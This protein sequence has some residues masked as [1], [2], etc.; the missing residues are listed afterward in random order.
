MMTTNSAAEDFSVDAIWLSPIQKDTVTS[1]YV[2]RVNYQDRNNLIVETPP[3]VL[4]DIELLVDGKDKSGVHK[5]LV[6]TRLQQSNPE[7]RRLIHTIDRQLLHNSAFRNGRRFVPCLSLEESF[8]FYIPVY[9]K[10]ISVLVT[11][12]GEREA[13]SM[14]N[15]QR[16]TVCRLTLLLSH[17]EAENE[18]F[19]PVWNIIEMKLT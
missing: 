3:L 14:N 8:L 19:L 7:F 12:G 9:N 17:V 15:I 5:I 2:S 1:R 10:E 16:G 18:V 13:R 4:N 11:K 6:R